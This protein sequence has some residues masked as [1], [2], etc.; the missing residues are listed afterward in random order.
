MSNEA[1][2]ASDRRGFMKQVL[3]TLAAGVG[4]A[5]FPTAARSSVQAWCCRDLSCPPCG[6]SWQYKCN[7]CEPFAQFCIC[8][9]PA[10]NCFSIECS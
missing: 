5:L 9:Q 1:P 2:G 3:G 10:G 6:G 4:I 8:H 7:G